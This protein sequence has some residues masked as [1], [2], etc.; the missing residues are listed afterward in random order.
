MV[1]GNRIEV[2]VIEQ[3]RMANKLLL[4]HGRKEVKNVNLVKNFISTFEDRFI[5]ILNFKNDND[6][7]QKDQ[8]H[9]VVLK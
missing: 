8:Y 7:N 2:E 9:L 6:E 4:V 3:M 5:A 1:K